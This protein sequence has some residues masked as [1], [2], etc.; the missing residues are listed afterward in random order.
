[1]AE[2]ASARQPGSGDAPAGAPASSGRGLRANSL[3]LGTVVALGLAYMS[4]APAV[5]FNMG[6]MEADA[7]GPVMPLIFIFVTI[8]ILPTAL[9]FAALNRRRPSAGSALTWVSESMGRSAGLWSGFLLATL[10][11]CACTIYPAYMAIFFNPLLEYFHIDATFLTG[12]AGGIAVCILVTWMMARNIQLSA[13]AIALFMAFE[14]AFVLVFA[15]YTIFFQAAHKGIAHPAAP[16]NP[17]AAGAGFSGLSLA[18]VFGILSIAGVDSV[19]PVAEEAKAPSRMIPLATILVTLGAGLFW[20]ISSY[21]FAT[22]VPVST[23]EKYVSQGLVTPVYGIAAQYIGGWKI[24]VPITGITATIASFGASVVCAS[25]LIYSIS[26]TSGGES[27]RMGRVHHKHDIPWNA[28][29]VAIVFAFIAPVVVAI[30]QGHNSSS[31]AGW[32]GGVFVFFA[33]VAYMMVNLANIVYH[34]RHVR[35]EFNWIMNGLIPVLGIAIDGYI[36][37]KAFFVAY[38]AES[39]QLGKSIVILSLAWTVIGAVWA[40]A[41]GTRQRAAAAPVATAAATAEGE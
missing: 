26:R 3:T 32:L 40:I 11:V 16:L 20:T 39:F 41:R 25:R 21:G 6:F 22:A 8:A 19:A 36:L 5:Y 29:M 18:V 34:W 14:A 1:M 35:A 30:W 17:H 15:L 10:Y 33:L 37:Y 28:S 31:A 9:S 2:H 23:V 7:N 4:L 27:R 13:R 12:L 24:L 38:M